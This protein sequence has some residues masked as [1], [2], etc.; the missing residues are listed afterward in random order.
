MFTYV[1][2]VFFD[3]LFGGKFEEKNIS[4]YK[5]HFF[6]EKKIEHF[7]FQRIPINAIFWSL[8]ALRKF[9]ASN[10]FLQLKNSIWIK[11]KHIFV[12]FLSMRKDHWK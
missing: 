3:N 9:D 7:L 6:E 12:I 10:I 8:C 1:D 4:S 5:S 2:N 11:F